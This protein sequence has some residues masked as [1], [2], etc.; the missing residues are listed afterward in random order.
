MNNC[1]SSSLTKT[2]PQPEAVQ[3]IIQNALDKANKSLCS[4]WMIATSC[5]RRATK[6]IALEVAMGVE[7]EAIQKGPIKK[8]MHKDIQDDSRADFVT[9]QKLS[10]RIQPIWLPIHSVMKQTLGF[11][12]DAS[13]QFR[14][15]FKV[16][17][18]T[19][20]RSSQT[21][22][23]AEWA[24]DTSKQI[25]TLATKENQHPKVLVRRNQLHVGMDLSYEDGGSL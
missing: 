20:G 9:P 25:D 11:S 2:D 4:P 1:V 13:D 10:L 22:S 14:P 17:K 23:S 7:Q 15:G 21:F 3:S 24:N 16:G 19:I 8:V 18:Q 6:A 12:K 5:W